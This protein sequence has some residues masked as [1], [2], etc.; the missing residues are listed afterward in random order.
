M[1]VLRSGTPELND[2]MGRSPII[3]VSDRMAVEGMVVP[4]L[5]WKSARCQWYFPNVK[6]PASVPLPIE[7]SR[8][9]AFFHCRSVNNAHNFTE[10]LLLKAKKSPDPTRSNKFAVRCKWC[11]AKSP[12]TC[13]SR[14]N[15]K[16]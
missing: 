13:L 6:E 2:E 7:N 14:E 4:F 11:C 8:T 9:S 12:I 5:L 10:T 3:I 15:L 16:M 1:S